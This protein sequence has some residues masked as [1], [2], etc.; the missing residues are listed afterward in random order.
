MGKRFLDPRRPRKAAKDLTPAEQE[1]RLVPFSP[2]LPLAP[3]LF[4][5]YSR[6]VARLTGGKTPQI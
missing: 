6:R 1:E 5:T 3:Q 4:A 2:L